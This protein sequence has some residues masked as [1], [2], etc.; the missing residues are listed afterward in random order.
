[1]A[2]FVEYQCSAGQVDRVQGYIGKV[3]CYISCSCMPTRKILTHC[4]DVGSGLKNN[5]VQPGLLFDL[6]LYLSNISRS[7]CLINKE[8][9][10]KFR[11]QIPDR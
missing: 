1:M 9:L 2:G 8:I 5:V 3:F 11:I 4:V 6:V 7:R 10:K